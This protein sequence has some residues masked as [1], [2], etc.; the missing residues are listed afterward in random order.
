MTIEHQ[1]TGSTALEP[2]V[3]LVRVLL[4]D[5]HTIMRQAL[6]RFLEREQGIEVCG[7]AG[8]GRE[9]I[10]VARELQPDL[11]L[12]DLAMPNLNGLDSTKRILK[13][14]P[15]AKV[16]VLTMYLDEEYVEQALEAGVVGY[17]LKSAE[18]KQIVAAVRTVSRGERYFTSE[19]PRY[20]IDRALD[21]RRRPLRRSPKLTHRE[22][23][24]LKLLA[25]GN[26]VKETA[27]VLGL[28]Q[29]TV[30]THKTN[31]MKKL[32]IHN[33]VELVRYAIDEKIIQL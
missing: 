10:E 2:D 12:M 24:V 1:T 5:D 21:E 16:M 27:K 14:L 3:K 17:V 13:A 22:R 31:L 11:I 23:E 8:D 20:F 15:D 32:D 19:I 9:A 28:S 4:V 7:E 25:E 30:D 29:K 33:R 26:T 18:P 6:R